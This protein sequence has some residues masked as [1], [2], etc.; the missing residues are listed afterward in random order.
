VA[1][2][3]F[4]DLETPEGKLVAMFFTGDDKVFPFKVGDAY[5]SLDKEVAPGSKI[6]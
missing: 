1:P 6:T 4:I 2:N 3:H 5:V